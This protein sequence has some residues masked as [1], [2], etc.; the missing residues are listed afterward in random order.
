MLCVSGCCAGPVLRGVDGR[1]GAGGSAARDAA[2]AWVVLALRMSAGVCDVWAHLGACAGHWARGT[3]CMTVKIVEECECPLGLAFVCKQMTSSWP[4]V[5][6]G[7][8][9]NLMPFIT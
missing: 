1:H 3:Y 5:S 9:G 8:E 4:H 7:H 6:G 2:G